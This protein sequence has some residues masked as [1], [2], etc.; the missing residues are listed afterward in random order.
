MRWV[1]AFQ[2]LEARGYKGAVSIE[3]EDENFN[4][5]EAGE[6]QGI[7]AGCNFLSSC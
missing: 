4:T 6:K 3:L 7:L 2:I 5:D 1:K